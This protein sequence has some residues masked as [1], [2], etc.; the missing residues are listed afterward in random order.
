MI[1]AYKDVRG[2]GEFLSRW[3]TLDTLN[4]CKEGVGDPI[5]GQ[6]IGQVEFLV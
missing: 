6:G 3:L 4:T 2:D 5:V 1:N